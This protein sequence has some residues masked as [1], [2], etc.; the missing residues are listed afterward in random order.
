[1]ESQNRYIRRRFKIWHGI[2]ALLLLLF[3]L[4]RVHGS[5]K[6]KKQIENLRTKGYPVTLEELDAGITFQMAQPMQPMHI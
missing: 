6:V 3:V 1:M 2:V 4:F 5:L